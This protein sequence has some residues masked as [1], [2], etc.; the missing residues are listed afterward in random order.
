MSAL[1]LLFFA[2]TA[3]GLA[4]CSSQNTTTSVSVSQIETSADN[5]GKIITV[6]A[7]QGPE[8]KNPLMAIWIENETGQFV[9]T[10][11]VSKSFAEGIFRYGVME[12]GKWKKGPRRHPAALPYF[13]HKFG[14]KTPDGLYLPTPENPVPDAVSGATPSGS[15]ILKAKSAVKFKR[16]K[17][18]LEINQPWDFNAY[19]FNDKYPGD[20]EFLGSGQPALVYSAD[21]DTDIPNKQF[22]LKPVGHSS[23]NGADGLLNS[24]L[25][26]LTTTLKIL[27][28]V[29][30]TVE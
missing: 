25:S 24:D 27:E 2:S 30:V 18:L 9:Q 19:W 13:S 21:V 11:Y 4:A 3:L 26:T 20:E 16:Y 28:E 14:N 17:I 29:T 10:L 23:Y 1:K 6:E 15:F 5:S 12:E 8:F 7:K 22:V